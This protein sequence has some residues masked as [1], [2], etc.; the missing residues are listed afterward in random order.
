LHQLFKLV[1]T[2]I[3]QSIS[4]HDVLNQENSTKP[5]ASIMRFAGASGA[6]TWSNTLSAAVRAPK[7]DFLRGRL[8]ENQFNQH[9]QKAQHK[10]RYA[11]LHGA[12]YM[13]PTG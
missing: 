2:K 13:R 3:V 8:Q 10:Y 7:G 6:F 1:R 9:N 11:F 12:N 4:Q 5:H